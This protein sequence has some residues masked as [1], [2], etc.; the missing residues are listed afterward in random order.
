MLMADTIRAHL[1][2]RLDEARQEGRRTLEF[3]A[4]TV[5]RELR[6]KLG[7]EHHNAQI[8]QVMRGQKFL[9]QA[10]VKKIEESNVPP[11][12]LGGNV[13]IRFRLIYTEA[14]K[15]VATQDVI[16]TLR[17]LSRDSSRAAAILSDGVD[18]T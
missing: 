4:G 15:M 16:N 6:Q 17:Q 9:Q 10:N 3:R 12:G 13:T 8:C 2:E 11:S 14:D 18:R 7:E 1:C 5:R